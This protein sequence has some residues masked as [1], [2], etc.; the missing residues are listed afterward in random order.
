[1]KIQLLCLDETDLNGDAPKSQ[2]RSSGNIIFG[3]DVWI[4]S[5]AGIT[6][7][8]SFGD[9]VVTAAFADVIRDVKPYEIVRG[10]QAKHTGFRIPE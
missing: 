7:G 5:H 3:K 4:A 8:A 2:P 10:N 9:C 6:C 1:M